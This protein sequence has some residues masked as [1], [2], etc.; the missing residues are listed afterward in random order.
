[1]KIA[2]DIDGVISEY[3]AFFRIL[4]NAPGVEVFILTN[5]DP[6]SREEIV[7]ELNALRI[8]FDHLVITHDKALFIHLSGIEVLFENTDEYFQDVP[9][10]VC[11]CKVR[12]GG[13]FNYDT[14]KWIYGD[15]TG[16]NVCR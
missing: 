4:S 13:N 3:P 11:V 2:L 6:E 15:K 8:R 5:R 14:K 16:E 12:E 9:P 1:M 10:E 7:A